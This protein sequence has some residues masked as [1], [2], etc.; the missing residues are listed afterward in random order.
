[1]T[2][3]NPLTRV[4]LALVLGTTAA[5]AP[6]RAECIRAVF[7]D[8]GNTLVDQ[9][10]SAPYPLFPTAQATIDTLQ[11]RGVRLGIITN[12]PAGWDRDD[13]ETLL[14]TPEMLDEF[15]ALA[16]S[17]EAPAPKPNPA[18]YTYA[19]NLL[20]E[21]RPAITASAFV[22]ENLDEIAN[23]AVP[24][25]LGARAV[26]M[27]GI[28]MSNAAPSSRADYTIPFQDVA[29]VLDV[30]SISCALFLDGFETGDPD[31]WDLCNG[32]F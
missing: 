10:V 9:S 20:A 2:T 17:S 29:A 28:H 8:L 4:A 30:V 3:M 11:A 1:M 32:C 15:E 23:T 26:G 14:A 13:L 18:I 25:T 12:V 7:F 22:G 31:G 6:A 5:T 19:W 21:P 16:M 24:P 27:I